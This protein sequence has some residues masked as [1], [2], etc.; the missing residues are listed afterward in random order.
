MPYRR[1]GKVV[2]HYKNSR[3]SK[4]QS[5]RSVDAAKKAIKL[6]RGLEHGTIRKKKPSKRA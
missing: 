6:L 1:R 5:C 4:K 2:E 3:W